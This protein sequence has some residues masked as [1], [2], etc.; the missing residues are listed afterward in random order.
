MKVWMFEIHN[1]E[2]LTEFNYNNLYILYNT[3]LI[4][5]LENEFNKL[6]TVIETRIEDYYFNARYKQG[7]MHALKELN[8][9]TDIISVTYL[10]DTFTSHLTSI[11]SSCKLGKYN[12]L[13]VGV[14][15]ISPS[16][17]HLTI[18]LTK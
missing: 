1:R 14:N 15:I 3:T 17:T 5:L 4:Y 11:L 2:Y 7:D 18:K 9:I 12:Q 6:P 10:L 13:I 16:I 8:C